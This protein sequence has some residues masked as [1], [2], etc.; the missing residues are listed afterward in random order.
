MEIIENPHRAAGF[1]ASVVIE[2]GHL[3]TTPAAAMALFARCPQRHSTPLLDVPLLANHCGIGTLSVK[4]ERQRMGLGSFKALGAAF[5]IAKH[6]A[7]CMADSPNC[8]T[9][10]AL[11]GQTFVCASAGNHGLSLAAGAR[12]F[13]AQA[14]VYLS[15]TVPAQFADRLRSLGA[16]VVRAG[17]V[18]EHSMAAAEQ[19]AKTHGWQLLSDSSWL[20]YAEPAQDVMEGYLI[21]TAEIAEQ[22]SHPPTHVFIQA[23][24]GGLAAASAAAVRHFWGESPLIVVVEPTSAPALARSIQQAQPVTTDGPVSCMGRLD[25]KAPSH[26]ALAYLAKQADYF[27]TIDD[28]AVT[29]TLDLLEQSNLKTTSSGAAGISALIHSQQQMNLD[30][31]SHVVAYLTESAV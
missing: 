23:G 27:V 21:I 14:V 13:G 18:Y 24:V 4:D 3:V 7:R 22:V 2:S 15:E 1:P 8:P 6:A 5:H 29:G 25:C 20:G 9:N 12:V 17:R 26:V 30:R 10:Q 19:A 11:A 31:Q 16:D 28:E